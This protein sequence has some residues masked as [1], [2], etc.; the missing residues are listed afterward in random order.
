MCQLARAEEEQEAACGGRRICASAWYLQ[1]QGMEANGA[2]TLP[3]SIAGLM[4]NCPIYMQPE[5]EAIIGFEKIL[6]VSLT[7]IAIKLTKKVLHDFLYILG[8]LTFILA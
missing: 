8:I 1:G 7:N 4:L 2:R 5:T 6:F 3:P